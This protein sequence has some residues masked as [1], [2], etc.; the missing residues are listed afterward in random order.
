M[1]IIS[2]TSEHYAVWDAFCLE[3]NDA[4]FWQTSRWLE[5]TLRYRP[6]Y[7]PVSH[8]FFLREGGRILAIAPLVLETIG[9]TREFSYGGDYGFTPAFASGLHERERRRSMAVVFGEIDR[10]ARADAVARVRFRFPV[11][12]TGHIEGTAERYNYL[13]EFGFLDTSFQTRVV[14]LRQPLETLKRDMR[15]GHRADIARAAKTLTAHLYDA[16]SII[17]EVFE[18]YVA[19]H[20]RAQEARHEGAINQKDLSLSDGARATEGGSRP[21]A[22]YDI[23]YDLI[24][25]GEGCLIGAKKEDQWV[26]FSYFF[27]FKGGAYY[28]SSCNDPEVQNLPI[29][30][31]IQWYAIEQLRERGAKFY[32][33][34]W[35]HFGPTLTEIPSPKE[36]AISHF[37]RGFGGM[38]VPLFRGEKYYDKEYFSKIYKAR[39]EAYVDTIA[40]PSLS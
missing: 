3:S 5:Y 17:P 20:H 9:C 34:G 31:V 28:G 13:T 11:L 8:S 15:H 16:G 39:L 6:E 27:L 18:S 24:L 30:H 36:I 10:R 37:K 22:T 12:N 29:A 32:E 7:A 19:L 14:D 25:R 33:I 38:T 1:E 2:L 35:Q 23:M 4:W 26:G 21:R 40:V